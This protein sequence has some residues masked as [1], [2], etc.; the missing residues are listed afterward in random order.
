[1]EAETLIQ[2]ESTYA[3][4]SNNLVH[5]AFSKKSLETE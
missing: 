2:V 1:M 4:F 3:S 5:R